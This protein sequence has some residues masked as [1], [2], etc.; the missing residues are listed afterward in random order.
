[1]PPP[2]EK[3]IWEQWQFFSSLILAMLGEKTSAF[4]MS[5][6]YR[7]LLISPSSVYFSPPLPLP[8]P[9]IKKM[10][11]F[12]LRP[13]CWKSFIYS[14]QNINLTRKIKTEWYM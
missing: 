5:L 3:S 14:K 11:N 10:I 1:M 7:I 6:R 4:F 13:L 9:H 12:T 8:P 2:R